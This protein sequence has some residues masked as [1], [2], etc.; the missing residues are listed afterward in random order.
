MMRGIS[1]GQTAIMPLCVCVCVCV[2][3]CGFVHA[4]TRFVYLISTQDP[5]IYREDDFRKKQQLS[6]QRQDASL[7]RG[8]L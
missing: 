4:H 2:C 1:K 3:V 6:L 5:D 7:Q 8:D